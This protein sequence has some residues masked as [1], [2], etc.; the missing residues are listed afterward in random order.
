V[1]APEPAA[2]TQGAGVRAS[3]GDLKRRAS[4]A[5]GHEEGGI[6]G[7]AAADRRPPRERCSHRNLLAAH[8]HSIAE[9]EQL[10]FAVAVSLL[11][12]KRI[13]F[14]GWKPAREFLGLWLVTT[15]ASAVASRGSFGSL[16]RCV[17]TGALPWR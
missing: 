13:V 14:A 2:S 5:D 6:A 4:H 12:A 17:R 1:D 3:A 16:F 10:L 7:H 15:R 9:P 11:L 8:E